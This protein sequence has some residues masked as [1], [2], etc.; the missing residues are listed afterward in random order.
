MG[1]RIPSNRIQTKYK[2]MLKKMIKNNE[3]NNHAMI[4]QRGQLYADDMN[5]IQL[6]NPINDDEE[7]LNILNDLD[8]DQ[9]INSFDELS[10]PTNAGNLTA[11][12]TRF[13]GCATKRL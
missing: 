13:G 4:R 1:D 10:I 3:A 2:K 8:C 12:L 11:I 7:M 6:N 9:S 5:V